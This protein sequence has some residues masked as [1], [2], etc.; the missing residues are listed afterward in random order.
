[1]LTDRLKESDLKCFWSKNYSLG[2]LVSSN[3][4][5]GNPRGSKNSYNQ[6]KIKNVIDTDAQFFKKNR[7]VIFLFKKVVN[8][9]ENFHSRSERNQDP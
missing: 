4:S 1:M 3:W 5:L 9:G 2:S 8:F 6:L 7:G